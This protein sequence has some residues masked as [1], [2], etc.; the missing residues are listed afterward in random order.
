MTGLTVGGY[1]N[2]ARKCIRRFV[3]RRSTRGLR[4]SSVE[5]RTRA[6]NQPS[7][8]LTLSK[9]QSTRNRGLACSQL[10]A[11]ASPD[12]HVGGRTE[13]G[14]GGSSAV[15]W[16]LGYRLVFVG[17]HTNTLHF[18]SDGRYGLSDC[19]LTLWG[20]PL[21]QKSLIVLVINDDVCSAR[22]SPPKLGRLIL[23]SRCMC[24][25]D[26]ICPTTL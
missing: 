5:Q 13:R 14:E 18:R 6:R 21:P 1:P 7:P 4:G 24:Y 19:A 20:A 17:I 3:C 12:V 23:L 9:H 11:A 15:R 8:L 22:Y 2:T 25:I 26:H 16:R 10:R